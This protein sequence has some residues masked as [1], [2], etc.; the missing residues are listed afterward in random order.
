MF[1][2]S[3]CAQ[4]LGIAWRLLVFAIAV[5]TLKDCLF[6]LQRITKFMESVTWKAL[7]ELL[8][9]TWYVLSHPALNHV[10]VDFTN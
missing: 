6:V 9:L 8:Q 2:R 4:I 10:S 7:R 1:T 5:I 3:L